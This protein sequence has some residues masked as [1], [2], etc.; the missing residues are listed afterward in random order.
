[1]IKK[2]YKILITF[3]VLVFILAVVFLTHQKQVQST[4][5]SLVGYA[6][7]DT[8]GWIKMTNDGDDTHGVGYSVSID[9]PSGNFS[10]YAWSDNIGWVDFAPTSG[11]PEAPNHGA[12]LVGNGNIV[13]WAQA[14]AGADEVDGWDGW[15]KM[16][17]TNEG[18]G[19]SLDEGTGFFTGYAWGSDVVGWVDFDAVRMDEFCGNGNCGIGEDHINCEVDCGAVCGDDNC[20]TDKGENYENCPDDCGPICGNGECEVEK[21]ENFV[22]CPDDCGGTDYREF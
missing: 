16:S 13:G 18:Y 15:I 17:D 20:E 1:M 10:G 2:T 14:L 8:I 6:W 5:G 19:V 21:E 11:Y 7:S 9:G 22:N 12:K 3:F 4:S